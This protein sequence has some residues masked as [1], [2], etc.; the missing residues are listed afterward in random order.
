[1][2]RNTR[3]TGEWPI[4]ERIG[5]ELPPVKSFTPEMRPEILRDPVEDEAERMQVPVDF[6]AVAT[7]GCL[8]GAVNRRAFIRPKRNDP[9]WI[10]PG[11]LWSALIGPPGVLAKSPIL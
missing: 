1:M 4:P 9:T 10:L 6:P 8:A 3:N 11:N 2:N 5:S 7:M